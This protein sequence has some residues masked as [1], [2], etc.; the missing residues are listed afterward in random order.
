MSRLEQSSTATDQLGIASS[1]DSRF[2]PHLLLLA[3]LPA[4]LLLIN[5]EWIYTPQGIDAWVYHG[6]FRN[7]ELYLTEF[8]PGTY[9]GSRLA[10]IL[11]GYIA[12]H[13]F[14][15][16]L[17]N[18]AL[19]LT[20]YWI[21]V[22][23]FHAIVK[24]A[25]DRN[26][27]L[28]ASL[29]FGC[30]GFFLAA[31]GWDYV[32][33]AVITYYLL[34][35]AFLSRAAGGRRPRVSIALAGAAYAAMIYTNIF[36]VIFSPSFPALYL[37]VDWRRRGAW[38][39]S[40]LFSFGLL[41][42]AGG[43]LLTALLGLVNIYMGGDFWFYAPSVKYA[44]ANANSDNPWRK[45]GW[46]WA[47][48]ARHLVLPV[49]VL[50][51]TVVSLVRS[52][53]R[54]DNVERPLVT[55]IAL[56]YLYTAGIAIALAFRGHPILQFDYKTT[57]LLPSV[58]LALGVQLCLV[59]KRLRTV[60]FVL[61]LIGTLVL[62][63]LPL[64]GFAA[65]ANHLLKGHYGVGVW[66]ATLGVCAGVT[67]VAAVARVLT[68]ARSSTLVIL[69]LCLA[70]TQIRTWT[71]TEV[72]EGPQHRNRDLFSRVDKGMAIIRAEGGRRKP[73]FWYNESSSREADFR[74]VSSTYLWG[75][76]LVGRKFPSLPPERYR[77]AAI[78]PGTFL[79]VLSEESDVEDTT[80]AAL[81]PYGLEA[82]LRSSHEIRAGFRGFYLTLFDLQQDCGK[83]VT[84]RF[85]ESN[86]EGYLTRAA[87]G[88]TEPLPLQ[89]WKSTRPLS[90]MT[91]E[92]KVDGLHIITAEDR[93]AYAAIYT[94]LAAEVAGDYTFVLRYKHVSGKIC[95]G[96]LNADQSSWRVQAGRSHD[97]GEQKVKSFTVS[98]AAGE[99]IWP[100]ITNDHPTGDQPSRVVVTELRVC[101]T[102]P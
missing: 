81:R 12:Y 19:H 99:V 79:V 46:E 86:P 92:Q 75:Y 98:L 57:L 74:S 47:L 13:I 3:I 77:K 36:A 23:S 80:M 70:A 85:D 88:R 16:V 50:V 82:R 35:M 6:Y 48:R 62:F 94:P 61:L 95:F 60:G 37:F 39:F 100:L 102:T 2:D 31:I 8:F 55:F 72:W 4:V 27:A 76:T 10:W 44:L 45:E 83:P 56:N 52:R 90:E 51:T 73:R 67:A 5:T 38:K 58:F 15:P 84:V 59:P 87:V 63:S 26:T 71:G 40:R 97:D 69:L 91:F 101:E 64:S 65:R 78:G 29:L 17:A 11:P 21:A 68:R 20:F 93:W 32:D 33:G 25:T 28:L 53:F 49:V 41:F 34:S 9:Y 30:H 43:L 54:G 66:A 24:S 42:A 96:A 14:P 89:R 7:L 1:R 18:Y 22:F